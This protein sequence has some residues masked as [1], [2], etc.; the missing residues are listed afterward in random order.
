MN[1]TVT[2]LAEHT[3]S[4]PVP[5]LAGQANIAP[6]AN[7]V[8]FNQMANDDPIGMGFAVKAPALTLVGI[9]GSFSY[10]PRYRVLPT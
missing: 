10:E 5:R 6:S 8:V 2:R 3:V 4:T 7:P 1:N 9:G